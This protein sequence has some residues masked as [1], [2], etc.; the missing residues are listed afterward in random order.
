M[1]SFI[2][3]A[4]RKWGALLIEPDL[5]QADQAIFLHWNGVVHTLALHDGA[6]RFVTLEKIQRSREYGAE[7]QAVIVDDEQAR[8]RISSH[9]YGNLSESEWRRVTVI[10]PDQIY[11]VLRWVEEEIEKPDSAGGPR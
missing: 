9:L 5:V 7:F 4:L 1:E 10:H 6:C 11:A 8:N 3:D 2:D